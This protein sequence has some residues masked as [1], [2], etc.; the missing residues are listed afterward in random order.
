M[1][2]WIS[3]VEGVAV[4]PW[5]AIDAHAPVDFEKASRWRP[6]TSGCAAMSTSSPVAAWRNAA[7]KARLKKA[8]AS[9]GWAETPGKPT[10]AGKTD[11]PLEP[12]RSRMA[13]WYFEAR[14]RAR[15]HRLAENT[16]RESR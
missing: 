9:R 2:A 7:S 13:I 15:P 1:L 14:S 3:S 8:F 5:M 4:P 12:A 10:F 11:Q 16:Q 6:K